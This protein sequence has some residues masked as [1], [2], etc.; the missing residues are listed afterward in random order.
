MYHSDQ[1]TVII[2]V[3]TRC[4]YAG[5]L[6]HFPNNSVNLGLFWNE[7]FILKSVSYQRNCIFLQGFLV[8]GTGTP[9]RGVSETMYKKAL[10]TPCCLQKD[11]LQHFAKLAFLKRRTKEQD[12]KDIFTPLPWPLWE[13]RQAHNQWALPRFPPEWKGFYYHKVCLTLFQPSSQSSRACY[14]CTPPSNLE[15][16]SENSAI[17][18]KSQRT[19]PGTQWTPPISAGR[20]SRGVGCLLRDIH[21]G[22]QP[23]STTENEP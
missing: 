18:S 13:E 23:P 2:I 20:V 5:T 10:P 4:G 3:E 9:A 6:Y 1:M 8:R 15:K 12:R 14:S 21:S 22:L 11:S 7:N 16:S 17:Y 19:H